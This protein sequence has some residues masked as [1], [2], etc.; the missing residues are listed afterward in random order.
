[1]I[2]TFSDYYYHL[3]LLVGFSSP[4]VFY[5]LYRTGRIDRFLWRFFWIGVAVGAT[6]E[7]PIFVLSGEPTSLPLISW[8]RP[9]P[10]HYLVFMVCHSLWDGLLFVIGI[11]LINLICPKPVLRRFSWKELAVLVAW[12]QVSELIVELSSTLNDGWVFYEYWWN[13]VIFHFNGHNIAVLMQVVWFAA[14][15]IYY[16]L[17]LK[18]GQKYIDNVPE[19][20]GVNEVA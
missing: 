15:V 12:G 3:D 5:L 11:R 1:M 9:L 7:I 4:V 18:L 16:F 10:A 8:V 20:G 14:A 6:W 2:E 17:L 13:P 19:F